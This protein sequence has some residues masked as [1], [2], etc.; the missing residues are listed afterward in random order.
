MGNPQSKS[1]LAL[2]IFYLSK[3]RNASCTHRAHFLCVSLL[4]LTVQ[5]GCKS[6]C[7][8]HGERRYVSPLSHMQQLWGQVMRVVVTASGCS[9]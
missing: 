7:L 3:C 5:R 6:K 9:P 1:S 4:L 8:G 2:Y